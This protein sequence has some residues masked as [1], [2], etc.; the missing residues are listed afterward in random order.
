LTDESTAHSGRAHLWKVDAMLGVSAALM[1]FSVAQAA[2]PTPP[3]QTRP[4]AYVV[5]PPAPALAPAPEPAVLIAF[6][7][8]LP[9][10]A[11]VSP[12]GRRQLPWEEQGRL[13][14]GVDIA[15]KA[16]RPI[17]A[18]ADGVV[19]RVG[20]DGGYG[21]FV[22]LKHAE[23][24]TTLYAHMG[25]VAPNIASGVAVKSGT[26]IGLVGS[27][28]SSTGAHLH[29]EIRDRQD[30]PLN[31]G[32]FLDRKFAT[33]DELPL[34]AAL[35]MPRG[36]RVAYVSHIPASKRGLMQAKLEARS[37]GPATA[38]VRDDNPDAV[39]MAVDKVAGRPHARISMVFSPKE[40]EASR[41]DPAA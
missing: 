2:L 33:S 8:P 15:A 14:A 29:F 37:G 17:L 38:D 16:G 22:E 35:R 36:T 4:I 41:S 31:P 9:G 1:A 19:V 12:F 25:K 7:E 24:L 13:H 40:D 27:T 6:A 34:R 10:Q 18:S 26:P 30:R 21:R 32:L 23:G 5:T 39:A 20:Q 28:G 3:A 11:I